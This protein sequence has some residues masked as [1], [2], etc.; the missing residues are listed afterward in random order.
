MYLFFQNPRKAGRESLDLL[1]EGCGLSYSDLPRNGRKNAPVQRLGA[2]RS[3]TSANKIRLAAA[4]PIA[5]L[6]YLGREPGSL[7]LGPALA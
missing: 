7:Q 6:N 4:T 2:S 3:R 5:L 1:G